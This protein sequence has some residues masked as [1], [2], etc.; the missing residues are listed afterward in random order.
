MTGI[1]AKNGQ[2]REGKLHEKLV[3]IRDSITHQPTA[4]PS[5]NFNLSLQ[6]Q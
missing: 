3:F 6:P 4:F 1:F 2:K 5:L